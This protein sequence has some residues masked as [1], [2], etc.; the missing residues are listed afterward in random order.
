MR[1]VLAGFV[2]IVGIC[3]PAAAHHSRAAFDTTVE[4]MIEGVI[5]D[6]LWANPH[7]YMTLDVQGSDGRSAQQQVEIG[8]LS[9]LGP[10]GLR[11]DS[12]VVG[13]RVTIRANPSRRGPGRTVVGLVAMKTDGSVYPLHVFGGGDRPAPL[14]QKA[15]SLAGKWVPTT[16]GWQSLVQG[17]RAWPL[18]EAGRQSVADTAS[19]Q[20]SQAECAPW[21]AP[22]FMTFPALFTIDVRSDVVAM[23][24]DWMN[25]ERTIHLN[26]D[27]HPANLAS[28]LQGHSIGHWDGATLVVDTVG[29]APHREG[30][31]FGVPSSERKRLTERITL[32]DDGRS[33]TYEFTVEDPLSLT[34]PVTRS[35]QWAYRPDLQPSGQSCDPQIATRFLREVGE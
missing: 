11:R 22:V 26:V 5:A 21:V 12:F 13:E 4:V 23:R 31:G 32:N 10:L 19:Q 16:Q 28:S 2:A 3:T 35:V 33:A 27:E 15:A 14:A 30:V 6:I 24:F 29:F 7:I 17:S 25:G 1:L 8:P 18:T 34:E 9:T 20:R